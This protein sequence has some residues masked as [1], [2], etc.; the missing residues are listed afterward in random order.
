VLVHS[1]QSF[2]SIR[3][4]NLKYL[5]RVMKSAI[6]EMS[7]HVDQSY[8]L[9]L[10]GLISS[11]ELDMGGIMSLYNSFLYLPHYEYMPKKVLN[12]QLLRVVYPLFCDGDNDEGTADDVM[13][14]ISHPDCNET[15][16]RQFNWNA[17]KGAMLFYVHYKLAS[18]RNMGPIRSN[19][20]SHIL[21][22]DSV[23]PLSRLLSAFRSSENA[24]SIVTSAGSSEQIDAPTGSS[25]DTRAVYMWVHILDHDDLYRLCVSFL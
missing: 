3:L 9:R 15:A 2:N 10:N 6:S 16:Y 22:R 25:V 17:R 23:G 4:D 12:Q 1:N 7:D 14:A 19:M 18:S 8:D 21:N 11:S 20:S 13:G 5:I 24:L